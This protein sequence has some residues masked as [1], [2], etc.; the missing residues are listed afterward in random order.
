MNPLSNSRSQR[1]SDPYRVARKTHSPADSY[2]SSRL[3]SESEA[4]SRSASDSS[5]SRLA[6]QPTYDRRRDDYYTDDPYAPRQA[7]YRHHMRQG[8]PESHDT[9]T[10]SGTAPLATHVPSILPP[11]SSTTITQDEDY[12]AQKANS[13][14][15]YSHH[16]PGKDGQLYQPPA[17]SMLLEP[18]PS[19]DSPS[20]REGGVGSL[21]QDN[22]FMDM[23][24]SPIRPHHKERN[25]LDPLP[26]LDS[27]KSKRRRRCCGLGRKRLAVLILT[28]I[29]IIILVWYFVWPRPF[30]MHFD[31]AN[32]YSN[33]G[34]AKTKGPNQ[35]ITGVQAIWN[36]SMMADNQANWVPTH[37][38]RLDLD[39]Y[40]KNTGI[41]FAGGSTDSFVLAPKVQ[42]SIFFIVNLN[43]QV[44]SPNDTTLQ[45]LLASCMLDQQ[46]QGGQPQTLRT[47]NLTFEVTYHIAGIA[48]TS[49]SQ[50]NADKYRCPE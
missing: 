37:V 10:S 25:A 30:E 27:N 43:Y 38:S 19:F 47:L 33:D 46:P 29:V 26:V 44:T 22:I 7:T 1:S 12:Q 49:K 50:H 5:T 23:V 13:Y 18:H 31:D 35:E 24:D 14:L 32:L 8:T 2:D 9:Y 6:S 28:F 17:T 16:P 36:V 48:W 11:N 4:H 15:P 42:Q 41:K 21:L 34:Y 39:V 20:N 3:Q 45:E 40:D